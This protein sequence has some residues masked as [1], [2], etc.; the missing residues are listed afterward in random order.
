M[1]I[2]KIDCVNI[3]NLISKNKQTFNLVPQ[4][5]ADSSSPSECSEL[6]PK[7]WTPTKCIENKKL[8]FNPSYWQKVKYERYVPSFCAIDNKEENERRKY[9]ESIKERK[10]KT[11]D[12]E[13]L[14]ELEPEEFERAKTLLYINQREGEQLDVNNIVKIVCLDS[15]SY[16]IAKSLLYIKGR[17]GEQFCGDE[18]LDFAIISKDLSD[19]QLECAQSLF[20]VEGREDNQLSL[21]EILELSKLDE[22]EFNRA[23]KL[24]YIKERGYDQFSGRDITSIAKL[25]DYDYKIA[26]D[27]L[28]IKGRNDNQFDGYDIVNFAKL[29]DFQ[30]KRAK[31]LFYIKGRGKKQ[32]SAS[33]INFLSSLDD[34]KYNKAKK[35]LYVEN[36]GENQLSYET[37]KY[38][39]DIYGNL[40]SKVES[41]LSIP[42]VYKDD[43]FS[44]VFF[45]ALCDYSDE[46]IKTFIDLI[47]NKKV[48]CFC[49]AHKIVTVEKVGEKY[50][51]L[52]ARGYEC[53]NAA[54]IANMKKSNE[55]NYEF[56][57]S[58]VTSLRVGE[59]F[60]TNIAE[61]IN[62]WYT[63]D[64]NRN[65][66]LT[67]FASYIK[68]VDFEEL[69]KIA[70][71][72]GNYDISEKLNFFQ[73]HYKAGTKE[74]KEDNLKLSKDLTRYLMENYVS[75]RTLTEIFCRYPLTSR[76]VG[77]IP[78]G[79]LTNI[80]QAMIE[81][82]TEKI[83]SAIDNFKKERNIKDFSK[84]MS[85][86]LNKEV[87]V[88]KLGK[89]MF[90]K[91][92]KIS[93][94]GEK[95][96]CLKLFY[97]GKDIKPTHGQ[98]IEVQIGLFVNRH[99]NDFVKMYFGKVAPYGYNDGFML[100]EYLSYDTQPTDCEDIQGGY[101][102]VSNDSN[103]EHNKKNSKI[104][105]FGGIHIDIDTKK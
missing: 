88:N 43:D 82:T 65:M 50:N 16:E 89:G 86:I 33:Q 78:T 14:S 40:D 26:Q 103:G 41:L 67:D 73:Y 53:K 9:L 101:R 35:L 60:D 7:K 85:E 71:Q 52:L 92:Y 55:S 49:N 13:W 45:N 97:G 22:K 83:Y 47:S 81:E 80:P 6:Y 99:S 59:T 31:E 74:F 102:I 25:S 21:N 54:I 51:D 12:I 48:D 17:E 20:Y 3:K 44:D 42:F 34:K 57:D 62:T 98:H 5:T 38:L 58:L 63:F 100:T 70:P 24:I 2:S 19:E 11:S 23:K 56:F 76:N 66:D 79:W 93:M 39:I 30:L 10:L 95:D 87:Q 36:L 105:D 69:K 27:F 104:F 46:Q 8:P 96:M 37:I 29:G 91:V 64:R 72:V 94:Y 28:Y 18:I 4:S 90:G 1:Y 61:D 68:S 77:Q 75:S 84:S 32:L 15:K